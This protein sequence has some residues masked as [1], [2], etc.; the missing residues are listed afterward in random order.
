MMH[1]RHTTTNWRVLNTILKQKSTTGPD[2]N[3]KYRVVL[4]LVLVVDVVT[5]AKGR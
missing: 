4:V 1:N 2:S 3:Y 5:D